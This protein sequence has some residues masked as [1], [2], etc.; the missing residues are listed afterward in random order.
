MI[1]HIIQGIIALSGIVAVILLLHPN[2]K[3]GRWGA[4]V[5]LAGQPFWLYAT[6]VAGA[7]GMFIAA[8]LWADLWCWV[9]YKSW[10]EPKV[11]VGP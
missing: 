8:V 11:K 5:G 1:D 9:I 6:F 7:W 3:L 2:K 4:F 10:I